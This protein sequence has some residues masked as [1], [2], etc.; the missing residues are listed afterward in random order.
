MLQ[1]LTPCYDETEAVSGRLW[2]KIV[3][4]TVPHNGPQSRLEGLQAEFGC[5]DDL[6]VTRAPKR[7]AYRILT[8]S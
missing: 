4:A 2:S 6:E 8:I 3:G 1:K 5:S 7:V